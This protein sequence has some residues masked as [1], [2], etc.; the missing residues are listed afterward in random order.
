MKK[1]K[2]FIKITDSQSA[3]SVNKIYPVLKEEIYKTD[4]NKSV[5]NGVKIITTLD[6]DGD[7]YGF[8]VGHD[9]KYKEVKNVNEFIIELKELQ[10]KYGIKYKNL[11]SAI[12]D[13]I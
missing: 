8:F 5:L 1:V 10:K 6:D 13:Q 11:H 12:I 2:T 9:A 4:D 3:L 7:E